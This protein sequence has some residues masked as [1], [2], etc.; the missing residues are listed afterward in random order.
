MGLFG[1]FNRN[2]E[3]QIQSLKGQAFKDF[4]ESSQALSDEEC[5]LLADRY[6]EQLNKVESK[7]YEYKV[8]AEA[9][10]KKVSEM[11]NRTV[12]TKGAIVNFT[13]FYE[14]R[15][16]SK[17]NGKVIDEPVMSNYCMKYHYDSNDRVVMVEEYS[18]FLKK[19]MTTE[20]YLY[21]DGCAEKLWFSS[22]VLARL[23]V[24]DNAF[25]NT[26]L[27]FS[28]SSHFQ[29]GK[30][31]EQFIYED[32]VLK[33]INI[34]QNDGNHKD[35]FIY[36]EDKLIMIEHFYPNGNRRL[37]Y[38]TKKPNFKKIQVDVEAQLEN[39]IREQNGE[40]NAF[41]I[42]GFLDQQ[43]PMMCVC[44]TKEEKPSDLIADWNVAMNNVKV[45]DWQFDENQEKKCVKMIAEIIV[46]LADEGIL[47][48]KQIYFHQN[49]VCVSQLYS[50]TKSIF[51]KANISV[52]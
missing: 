11:V 47:S 36:E 40:Y 21:Y 50:G 9:I 13:P 43:L 46:A 29:G 22:G 38:T 52:K 14:E 5:H 12:V 32:N 3:K 49:Q 48:G 37:R 23:F 41:G 45:Y 10:M 19:F 34:G 44:F 7:F 17:L 2:K 8:D 28:F 39:I 6:A 42:E 24:F 51:K 15:L 30:V 1:K 25:A 16:G 33:E 35:V 26:K 31:V 18:T 4:F 27:C 20:I